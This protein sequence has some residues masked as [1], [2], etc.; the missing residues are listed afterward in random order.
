MLNRMVSQISAS[1][2]DDLY[3]LLES[4]SEYHGIS[5]SRTVT[6]F[7]REGVQAR[8]LRI[9]QEI[10]AAK[11]DELLTTF[12]T[13]ADE[14]AQER[15]KLAAQYTLPRG[16]SGTELADEPHPFFRPVGENVDET[17]DYLE[18]LSERSVDN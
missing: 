18:L 5:L 3:D 12:G 13:D 7:L 6:L 10:L 16:V 14:S 8:D 4:V 11:V 15:A 9:R 2:D 17:R 1:V